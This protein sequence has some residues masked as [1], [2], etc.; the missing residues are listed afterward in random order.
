MNQKHHLN[1]PEN[2]STISEFVGSSIISSSFN[3]RTPTRSQRDNLIHGE[4]DELIELWA[5]DKVA[6][7][8]SEQKSFMNDAEF[9]IKQIAKSINNMEKAGEYIKLG[10]TSIENKNLM[11]DRLQHAIVVAQNYKNMAFGCQQR[12]L[13]FPPKEVDAQGRE[14]EYEMLDMIN[15]EIDRIKKDFEKF[16]TLDLT[17]NEH[18]KDFVW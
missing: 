3:D 12:V 6:T 8:T 4:Q 2:Q 13:L 14:E 18:F 1:N 11:I 10:T 15:E 16:R 9:I 17:V 5:R 7:L